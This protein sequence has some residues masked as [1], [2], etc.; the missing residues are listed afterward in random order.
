[1][2]DSNQQTCGK[3]LAENSILPAKLGEL[4]SAMANNLAVHRKA[5]DRTDEN[6]RAEDDAYEK[7][8]K[9]LRQVAAQLS[10]TANQMAEYR[11]LPMGRH[12]QES[13]RHPRV[14]EAF[15][16][17]VQRKRELLILLEQTEER[18]NQLLD[19]MQANKH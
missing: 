8:L 5:L 7:L 12:D 9:D 11:D 6:S 14:Q 10:V 4:I 18:D 15:E 2:S 1:M 13:M 16:K 3:G 17:F 19:M